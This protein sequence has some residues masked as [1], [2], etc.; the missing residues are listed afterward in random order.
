MAHTLIAV[1]ISLFVLSVTATRT[2]N[3][4]TLLQNTLV[5]NSVPFDCTTL[6]P[7]PG[8]WSTNSSHDMVSLNISVPITLVGYGFV[9]DGSLNSVGY[10]QQLYDSYYELLEGTACDYNYTAPVHEFV[11]PAHTAHNTTADTEG[12]PST[13]SATDIGGINSY[14]LVTL[15]YFGSSITLNAGE[16]WL[17]TFPTYDARGSSL[18]RPSGGVT[19]YVTDYVSGPSPRTIPSNQV[20]PR[21]GA[22]FPSFVLLQGFQPPTPLPPSAPVYPNGHACSA[23]LTCASTCCCNTTV[24]SLCGAPAS[25]SQFNG[26]CL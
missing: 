24:G 18:Y 2:F 13:A 8:P 3:C 16:F 7:N 6:V 12:T 4:T 10:R 22:G 5:S 15:C 26:K 21:R 17:D 11:R 19:A 1:A 20:V 23:S 9:T 25:C 14:P